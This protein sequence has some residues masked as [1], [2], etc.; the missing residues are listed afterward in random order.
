MELEY[1]PRKTNLR[2]GETA[3]LG[4]PNDL[5]SQPLVDSA[6]VSVT[7]GVH[8]GRYPIGGMTVGEARRR[9]A[10]LIN[11]DPTAI[12]VIGG[13]PVPDDL[14]IGAGVSMLAFVKPSA[15]KGSSESL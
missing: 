2:L 6:N 7:Y 11:I 4:E 5:D 13:A 8:H 15:M 14:Q 1:T 10:P 9:L 3:P 12:A